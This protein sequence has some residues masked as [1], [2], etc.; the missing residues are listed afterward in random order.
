MQFGE[1][2]KALREKNNLTQ[3]DVA[4]ALGVTQRAISYYENK[5]VIPNDPKALNKLAEFFNITLD[6]LLLKNEGSKSKLHALVEKL[7]IDTQNRHIKWIP[8]DKAADDRMM[9]PSDTP[10]HMDLFKNHNFPRLDYEISVH[11][12]YFA[13]YKE[14]GY[15][16]S[17]WISNNGD[18]DIALFIYLNDKFSYV[19][20]KD[21]ITQIDE[22]YWTLTNTSSNISEF[23]DEYLDDDLEDASQKYN[24][25]NPD[26]P[27]F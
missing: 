16:L 5:N 2:L 1:K 23:I 20:N 17:K 13:E 10:F 9:F 21:S 18:V 26:D 24:T 14:G 8:L 15:L 27:P 11:E 12:S 7:T 25:F 22:L 4:Q 6:E 19:A 3:T